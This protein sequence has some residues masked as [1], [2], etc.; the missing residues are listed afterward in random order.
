MCKR[1]KVLHAIIDKNISTLKMAIY[2]YT[3]YS[4]T[5]AEYVPFHKNAKFT[6]GYGC[7]QNYAH[8]RENFAYF[9]MY[10]YE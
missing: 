6:T 5:F 3:F 8:N 2:M 4:S 9:A 7:W 1:T 10:M